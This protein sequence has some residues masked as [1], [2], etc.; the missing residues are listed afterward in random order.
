MAVDDLVCVD[1]SNST[2]LPMALRATLIGNWQTYFVIDDNAQDKWCLN[3][4]LIH[5]GTHRLKTGHRTVD[6]QTCLVKLRVCLCVLTVGLSVLCMRV[7]MDAYRPVRRRKEEE[8]DTGLR[9]R[10]CV[11]L[12]ISRW[13]LKVALCHNSLVPTTPAAGKRHRQLLSA[14]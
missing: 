8:M 11:L 5:A 3:Y 6:T 14:S 7:V 10:V 9:R 13:P 2:S 1:H 12:Y 4:N